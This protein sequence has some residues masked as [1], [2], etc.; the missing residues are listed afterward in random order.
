MIIKKG[1]YVYTEI[2]F[3]ALYASFYF[4]HPNAFL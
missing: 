1:N 2:T 4:H 3:Q